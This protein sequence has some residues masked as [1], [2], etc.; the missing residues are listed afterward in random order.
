[1][2]NFNELHDIPNIL[3][4]SFIEHHIKNTNEMQQKASKLK[5]D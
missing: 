3:S 2:L 4:S 5:Q 1:M